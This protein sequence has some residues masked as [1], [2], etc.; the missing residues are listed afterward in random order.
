VQKDWGLTE[1]QWATL[2]MVE[3]ARKLV[4]RGLEADVQ[5]Y[6]EHQKVLDKHDID[7]EDWLEMDADMQKMKLEFAT[8]NQ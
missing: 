1:G 3:R 8:K 7:L 4:F 5:T 6:Y 2:P